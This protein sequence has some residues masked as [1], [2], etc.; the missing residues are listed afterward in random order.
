MTD[1]HF[2]YEDFSNSFDSFFIVAKL[3]SFSEVA[4]VLH[5]TTSTVSYRIKTLETRFD[6]QLLLFIRPQKVWTVS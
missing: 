5:K 6:T 2:P 1:G 4:E 3:R